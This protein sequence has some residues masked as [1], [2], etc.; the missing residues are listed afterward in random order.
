[1]ERFVKTVNLSKPLTILAK[2]STLDV[3][4][5]S[6]YAQGPYTNIFKSLPYTNI[7]QLKSVQGY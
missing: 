4:K 1:M 3:W 5:D 7:V 6:E 2:R